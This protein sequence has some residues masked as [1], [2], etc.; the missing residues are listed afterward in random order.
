MVC[1]V[2]DMLRMARDIVFVDPYFSC[3]PERNYVE[4]LAACLQ[5]CI[6]QRIPA[7]RPRIRVL[8]VDDSDD[9]SKCTHEFFTNQCRDRLPSRLPIGHQVEI[10]RVKARTN[11][12]QL[13]NRYILTELGGVSFGAGLD[14]KP[15]AAFDD[16]FLLTRRQHEKRWGQYAAEPLAFDRP[17]SVIEIVGTARR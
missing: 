15:G 13:H 5:A 3:S 7:G 2:R 17:E 9:D 4:V 16:V 12:E 10:S 1:V 14:E 8:T 6:D 11:G